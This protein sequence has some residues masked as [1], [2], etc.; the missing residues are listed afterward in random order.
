MS[1]SVIIRNTKQRKAVFDCLSQCIDHPTAQ[2]LGEVIRAE[3]GILNTATVYRTLA[4]LVR[5]GKVREWR[6]DGQDANRYETNMTRHWHFICRTC[7]HVYDVQKCPI[8]DLAR[9]LE[10]TGGTADDYRL[11]FYGTCAHCESLHTSET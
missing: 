6:F 10:M 3:G 1:H 8:P 11:D 2:Q 7:G 4:A 9:G 5:E